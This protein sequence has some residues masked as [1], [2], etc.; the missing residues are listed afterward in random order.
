MVQYKMLEKSESAGNTKWLYRIDKQLNSEIAR[1]KQFSIENQSSNNEYRLNTEIFYIK[2][3]KR[4]RAEGTRGMVLPIEHFELLCSMPEAIGPRGG[5]R[6]DYDSL[7]GQYLRQTA[8]TELIRSGYIG[9]YS[10]TTKSLEVLIEHIINSGRSVVAAFQM[11][12]KS[13]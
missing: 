4:D 9:T 3:V 13:N 1:M 2:F 6:I 5:I 7:S 8:F 11:K 12:K 10:A